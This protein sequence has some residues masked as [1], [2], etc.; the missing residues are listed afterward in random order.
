MGR[1]RVFNEKKSS[2]TSVKLFGMGK[3]SGITKKNFKIGTLEDFE[4]MYVLYVAMAE[5][6]L[7]SG[8]KWFLRW[9]FLGFGGYFLL[10]SVFVFSFRWSEVSFLRYSDSSECMK[11]KIARSFCIKYLSIFFPRVHSIIDLQ[12]SRDFKLPE[13]L[14]SWVDLLSVGGMIRQSLQ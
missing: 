3:V 13:R 14:P 11:Q 7:S 8:Q 10:Q 12:L 6:P 1:E 5:K 9:V 2:I 4:K